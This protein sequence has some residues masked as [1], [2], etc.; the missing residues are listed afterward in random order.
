MYVQN[1]KEANV[2]DLIDQVSL[3]NRM[4]YLDDRLEDTRS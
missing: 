2:A 4:L 1:C 3:G